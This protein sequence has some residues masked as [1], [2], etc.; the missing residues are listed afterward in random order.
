MTDSQRRFS[1][2]G[3]RAMADFPTR[4]DSGSRSSCIERHRSGRIGV[5]AAG[6]SPARRRARDALGLD[7]FC[8]ARERLPELL[9]RP[10]R[11]RILHVRLSSASRRTTAPARPRPTLKPVD[12]ANLERPSP[13]RSLRV[14]DTPSTTGSLFAVRHSGPTLADRSSCVQ[15]V[16]EVGHRR[17][18]RRRQ[19]RR[20][21]RSAPV[22]T[23]RVSRRR[24]A[25]SRRRR[26]RPTPAQQP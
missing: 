14:T 15:A 26:A 19:R 12:R 17:D 4:S 13:S 1:P 3:P 16:V 5:A 21:R 18:V 11:A 23:A 22:G 10:E 20:D 9:R 6:D 24:G 25:G 7:G 2:Y 8:R